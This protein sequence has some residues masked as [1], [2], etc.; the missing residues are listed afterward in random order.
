MRLAVH[1]FC[2]ASVVAA[3]APGALA[4]YVHIN[5]KLKAGQIAIRRVVVLPA[6]I[7]LNASGAAG[8][9]AAIPESDKLAESLYTA[10]GGE[11]RRRG[12]ELV[13]NP[14]IEPGGDAVKYAVADLQSRYDNVTVQLRRRPGQVKKGEFT[15][16]DRVARFGPGASADALVFLRG[17]GQ[18][19][20]A[21]GALTDIAGQ[22]SGELAF[23]DSKTG[24]V[25][26]YITFYRWRNMSRKTDARFEATLRAALHDVPLPRPPAIVAQP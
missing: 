7:V 11:L 23:V 17:T 16:G 3:S 20:K 5:A 10:V 22:F 25:L 9:L 4:Q 21:G 18:F 14:M 13:P 8:G 12:V 1:V 24:E 26:V 19:A 15:L 6:E 2:A